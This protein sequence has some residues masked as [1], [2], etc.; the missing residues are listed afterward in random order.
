MS[1]R[2]QHHRVAKITPEAFEALIARVDRQDAV[3]EGMK[4]QIEVLWR[5]EA[6]AIVRQAKIDA[7][8]LLAI[9]T[10]AY[11]ARVSPSTIRFWFGRGLPAVTIGRKRYVSR[12][13]LAEFMA[14]K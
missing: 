14:R 8:G 5:A 11:E 12:Q 7:E 2:A 10:A 9:K 13:A 1:A 6:L 4:R 3:I